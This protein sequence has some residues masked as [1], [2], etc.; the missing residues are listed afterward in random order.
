MALI[1]LGSGITVILCHAGQIPDAFG[2]ILTGAF[3]PQALLGGVGGTYIT[4]TYSRAG[5][6]RYGVARG[7]F[8]NEAGMGSSAIAHAAARTHIPA[9][10][11]MWGIFEV[12]L[13][14]IVVCS[15][16]AL[17]I[18]TSGVYQ[19][20]QAL[21]ALSQNTVD[22]SMLGAPLSA[23]AFQTVF[24]PF[25]GIL[26]TVCLLLFAFT[27]LLGWCYYGEQALLFLTRT[28]R[29]YIQTIYRMFF[30]MSIVL[31]SVSDVSAA[32]QLADIL[33]GLM[34]LPN[35]AALLLLSPE[36]LGLLFHWIG[37]KRTA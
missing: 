11:G 9:E 23:A 26:I 28:Q 7:V 24:G 37:Q 2:Q 31:G 6:L 4:R 12:F 14:T 34:A 18:L 21:A 10:Q 20:I 22:P 16:T 30:L 32:W 13:A 17:T 27:S 29:P 35:L 3:R 19:P 1:F 15:V 5:A 36:A 25:G 33:N 8:T